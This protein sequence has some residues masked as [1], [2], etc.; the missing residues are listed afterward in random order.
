MAVYVD[1]MQ[2]GFGRMKMCHMIA[3]SQKELLEMCDKIGVQ[4]NGIIGF[5]AKCF[6]PAT[7]AEYEKGRGK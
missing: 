2:V 4:H 7:E 5:M 3:D 1:N 6:L